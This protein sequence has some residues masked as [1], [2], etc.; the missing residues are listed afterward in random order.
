MEKFWRLE[1]WKR[2]PF[3]DA[4]RL[5]IQ[6]EAMETEMHHNGGKVGIGDLHYKIRL[7]LSERH[8]VGA[9][10]ELHPH[11]PMIRTERCD[12]FLGTGR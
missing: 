2:L 9:A 3:D 8:S 6:H 5:E 7:G 11:L 1:S 10:S 4:L 12:S